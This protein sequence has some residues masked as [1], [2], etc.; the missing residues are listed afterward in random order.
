MMTTYNSGSFTVSAIIR[1]I[2]AASVA[3]KTGWF[4][5]ATAVQSVY[6]VYS[7]LI[8]NSHSSH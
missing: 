7:N 5:S 4:I 8:S 1:L 6:G 2:I 3:T